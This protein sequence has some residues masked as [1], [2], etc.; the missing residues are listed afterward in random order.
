MEVRRGF[1]ILAALLM[2]TGTVLADDDS[3][4]LD[5]TPGN[6]S[7]D[8][9]TEV[10]ASRPAY[11]WESEAAT[12]PSDTVGAV[13]SSAPAT[14][15]AALGLVDVPPSELRT[16]EFAPPPSVP[17]FPGFG[18]GILAYTSSE[19][20]FSGQARIGADVVQRLEVGAVFA[21]PALSFGGLTL[22]NLGESR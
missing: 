20:T 4:L 18:G 13:G 15:S 7:A 8:P 2:G 22:L 9:Q 3:G 21:A 6:W 1:L 12:P 5:R 16:V 17:V 10:A 14:L 11:P 19:P